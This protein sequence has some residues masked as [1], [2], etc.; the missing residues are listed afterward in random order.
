[1]IMALHAPK[2]HAAPSL[3][4]RID[5]IDHRFDS[6]FF[7]VGSAFVIRLRVSMAGGRDQIVERWLWQ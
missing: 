3:P 4:S 2:R 7:I 6:K 1:M 5:A